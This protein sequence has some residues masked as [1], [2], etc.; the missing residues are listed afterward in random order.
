M[1]G[2]APG[3]PVFHIHGRLRLGTM[4]GWHQR[5]GRMGF[6]FI[7][8]LRKVEL[9]QV[10]PASACKFGLLGMQAGPWAYVLGDV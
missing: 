2:N 8:N 10:S 5:S 1:R 3:L 9:S 4:R 6:L 7:A